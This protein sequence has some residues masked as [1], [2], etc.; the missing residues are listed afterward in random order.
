[1]LLFFSLLIIPKTNN[2]ALCTN[3]TDEELRLS[4]NVIEKLHQASE[5]AIES[6]FNDIGLESLPLLISVLQMPFLDNYHTDDGRSRRRPVLNHGLGIIT[7]ENEATV[8]IQSG[9][10]AS[11]PLKD[12]IESVCI[13]LLCYSSIESGRALMA[14]IPGLLLTLLW[15]L[16]KF[17][18]MPIAARCAA[19]TVISNLTS[20]PKNHDIILKT[21]RL[22]T[23]IKRLTANDE[24]DIIRS[25]ASIAIK[26]LENPPL[27]NYHSSPLISVDRRTAMNHEA[28]RSIMFSNDRL[29]GVRKESSISSINRVSPLPPSMT[30]NSNRFDGIPQQQSIVSSTFSLQH[31]DFSEMQQNSSSRKAYTF[32]SQSFVHSNYENQREPSSQR[33]Y[34]SHQFAPISG[35]PQQSSYPLNPGSSEIMQAQSSFHTL[36]LG[37]TMPAAQIP[38]VSP[39]YS[40]VGKGTFHED[41]DRNRTGLFPSQ[42]DSSTG[43]DRDVEQSQDHSSQ[44]LYPLGT[45]FHTYD[46]NQ[47]SSSHQ[48]TQQADN[49]QSADQ[50]HFYPGNQGCLPQKSHPAGAY[51]RARDDNRGVNQGLI[52][53]QSK[54]LGDFNQSAEKVPLYSGNQGRSYRMNFPM[55]A[56]F[57]NRDSNQGATQQHPTFPVDTHQNKQIPVNTTNQGQSSRMLSFATSFRSRKQWLTS[58][59]K[60]TSDQRTLHDVSSPHTFSA[61]TRDFNSKL[62]PHQLNQDAQH[63]SHKGVQAPQQNTLPIEQRPLYP[64]PSMRSVLLSSAAEPKVEPRTEQ[65]K[66]FL[67]EGKSYMASARQFSSKIGS[68]LENSALV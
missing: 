22:L 51:F 21:P 14:H 66:R 28:L 30:G 68:T 1:M 50:I 38:T 49:T 35:T 60:C 43:V 53:E 34:P 5:I 32:P 44:T 16:D 47:R 57:R 13:T 56:S 48:S 8:Q 9:R 54:D 58:H 4:C 29:G 59:S 55:G 52:A 45:S 36:N 64:Y 27:N 63:L 18:S 67:G 39:H 33:S 26:N 20:L 7:N 17:H 3:P 42:S 12:A 19:I 23:E 41:P 46:H 15:I 37:G 31:S 62:P 25:N 40:G 6:T 2:P 11:E 10:R 65:S 24:H 61:K